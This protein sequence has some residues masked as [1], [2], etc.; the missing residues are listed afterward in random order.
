MKLNCVVLKSFKRTKKPT[1][2]QLQAEVDRL[3]QQLVTSDD[4]EPNCAASDPVILPVSTATGNDDV[5]EDSLINSQP[6]GPPFD[7]SIA[8]APT[9]DP[10]SFPPNPFTPDTHCQSTASGLS[11]TSCQALDD[12]ELGGTQIADCFSLFSSHYLP[13]L[14]IFDSSTDPNSCYTQSPLLFWTIVA[15]G[16]RKYS[17]DPTIL[18][19]LAP[20]VIELAARSMFSQ[21][22]RLPTIQAYLLLCI[23][24]MPVD[25]LHKDISTVLSGAMLSLA[26]SNGLHVQGIGQDFSRT[27]LEHNE[28]ECIY[29]AKLWVACTVASQWYVAV[30]PIEV[31]LTD[32]STAISNGL[33]PPIVFDTFDL[34]LSQEERLAIV[35]FKVR[36]R[37]KMSQTL[38]S[39]ILELGRCVQLIGEPG[40]ASSVK[41]MIEIFTWQFMQMDSE[42]PDQFSR[43]HLLCGRLQ[44]QSFHFFVPP[45]ERDDNGLAKLYLLACSVI[46]TA[47]GLDE[48]EN[49][50]SSATA[51]TQKMLV[52]ASFAVLRIAKSHLSPMLDVERGRKAY[53]DNILLFRKIS[54]QDS[55]LAS[56]TTVILTQLWT[57]RNAFKKSD[58]T[59]DSLLL[60]CRSRLSMSVVFDCF[61]RWRREFA[62]QRTPYKDG[63]DE[64]GVE[65][66]MLAPSLGHLDGGTESSKYL[67]SSWSPHGTF[68]DYDWLATFDVPLDF[69]GIFPPDG[70]RLG[71]ETVSYEILTS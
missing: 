31:M 33:P 38:A 39:C 8:C 27:T 55:D 2:A 66:T 16:A 37:K 20:K 70:Q 26:I 46:E 11:M 7:G 59:T 47:V 43:L 17:K 32:G 18:T 3:K 51:Y 61:W 15:I 69:D 63:Q 62:G 23:W 14:Y 65:S 58:G 40:G 29:R 10:V 57:S 52:L 19:L 35:P 13:K 49:F 25:S 34:N 9:N 50:S 12:F 36:F 4:F 1:R 28:N 60:L 21:T 71:P 48:T 6:E 24:P 54:I 5:Q 64:I 42:C 67:L 56:R 22:E 30:S 44:S 45:P 68:P 53:F 41:S